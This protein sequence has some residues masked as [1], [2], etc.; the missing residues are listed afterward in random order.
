[1]VTPGPPGKAAPP[2]P[3]L[4][5][6]G[7]TAGG[8]SALALAAAEAFGGT[9]INA[10]SLQVYRELAILTARPDAA[11]EARLPHRLYGVLPAAER[12]S[13]G[14]WAGLAAAAIAAATAAGRLPILV[15][16]TGLYLR[17]LLDG[18]APIPAVPEAALAEAAARLAALG[19][20]AF[21]AELARRD[22]ATAA[23]LRPGDPQRLARAWAVLAATGRPLSQ[24]Q[25]EPARPVLPL[26]PLLL[27][28]EPDRARLYRACD[29]R[30]LA[31]LEAGALD[32][33]RALRALDLD[34]GLPAM[35][36]VGVRQL[37]DHLAGRTSLAAAVAAAQQATRNYA[38]RQLT[39]FRHQ[40]PGAERLEPYWE[41][42]KFSERFLAEV[43]SKI[44]HFQ[45]TRPGLVT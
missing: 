38:K 28:L 42:A 26:D 1:M 40:L 6:A 21:H 37:L 4:V 12:C 7:P 9:V 16:G 11:A 20:A 34:P 31:M 27:R 33:A 19:R 25:A 35:K 17:A 44:R 22:P 41:D 3:V 45:L 32:E 8:K 43:F 5:I 36:A 10:D 24:W 39:W 15:G 30:F 18:L 14:R 23:R 2:H 13:A 29:A